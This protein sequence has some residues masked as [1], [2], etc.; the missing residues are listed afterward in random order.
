MMATLRLITEPDHAIDNLPIS[1]AEL[2]RILWR[3]CEDVPDYIH[4]ENPA[5]QTTL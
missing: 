1:Q 5:L 4:E 2:D 3:E